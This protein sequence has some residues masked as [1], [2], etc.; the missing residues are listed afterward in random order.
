ML[1]GYHSQ[2]VCILLRQDAHSC[3]TWLPVYSQW[4]S[5]THLAAAGTSLHES[6]ANHVVGE[7]V[8]VGVPADSVIDNGLSQALQPVRI[9]AWGAER[10]EY[11][12]ELKYMPCLV[13]VEYQCDISN[14]VMSWLIDLLFF[15]IFKSL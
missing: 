15:S 4:F 10:K 14:V 9:V 13:V 2:T 3:T 12:I 1:S 7:E 6:G 8:G 5:P 11:D